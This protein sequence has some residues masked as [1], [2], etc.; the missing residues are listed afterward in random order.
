MFKKGEKIPMPTPEQL[1]AEETEVPAY[2][3]FIIKDSE[4]NV[5]RELKKKPSGGMQRIVWDMR[6]QASRPV[7][8]VTKFDVLA[9][10]GSGIAVAPGKY[11][12]TMSLVTTGQTKVLAGPVD[13]VCRTIGSSSLPVKD[14]KALLAFHKKVTELSTTVRGTQ[15]YAQELNQRALNALQAINALPNA[16]PELSAKAKA[17]L[18]QLDDILNQKFDRKSDFPSYEENPPAPV[19]INARLGTVASALWGAANEPTQTA[20]DGY[21][22]LM[23]EFPPVYEQVKNWVKLNCLN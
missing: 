22:I 6:Y 20:I 16:T 21:N 23:E 14:N 17:I 13:F 5:V 12:V 9:D 1:K 7:S 18:K 2:I 3:S 4:G 15:S 10:A 8:G 11:N 19:T